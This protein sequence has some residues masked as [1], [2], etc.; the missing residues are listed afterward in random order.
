MA[1]SFGH[2]ALVNSRALQLAGLTAKTADPLG[3]KVGTDA[4]GNPSGILEDAAQELVAKHI[5][6]P[7]PADDVKSAKAAL[8]AMRKQGVTTFLDAV[9]EA[10][11]LAAFAAVQGAGKL[12]ARAHFAV[13][14]TPPEGPRSEAGGRQGHGARASLRSGRHR[15]PSPS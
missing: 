1:S 2:T 7:T 4:A 10:P 8:D 3:G 9:A 13:L 12:T 14:I 5:P 15:G 6:A 11:S